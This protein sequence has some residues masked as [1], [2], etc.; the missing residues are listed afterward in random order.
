[1]TSPLPYPGDRKEIVATFSNPLGRVWLRVLARLM[2]W[3]TDVQPKQLNYSDVTPQLAVGGA[4]PTRQIC[5][6]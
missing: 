3:L 5:R 1:L 4:F 2:E 6:L